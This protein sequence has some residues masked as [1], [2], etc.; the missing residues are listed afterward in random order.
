MIDL[1]AAVGRDHVD[2][3]RLEGKLFG[4]DELAVVDATL[5]V[6]ICL[7]VELFVVVVVVDRSI[8]LLR[9]TYLGMVC[10]RDR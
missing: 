8:V 4:K 3:G 7:V 6:F 1:E 10:S 5:S 9:Y 2:G